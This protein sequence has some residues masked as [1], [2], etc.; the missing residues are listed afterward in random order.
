[1]SDIEK[2]HEKISKMS[3]AD[4]CLLVHNAIKADMEDKKIEML[5]TY[6][7]IAIGKEKY[8]KRLK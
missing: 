1:M 2:L 6:L 3:L 7:E 8:L 5:L 4:L